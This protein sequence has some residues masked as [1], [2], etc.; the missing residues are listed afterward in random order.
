MKS[1]K[2]LLYMY[3]LAGFI[4]RMTLIPGQRYSVVATEALAEF[5]RKQVQD[6]VLLNKIK[7]ERKTENY[8]EIQVKNLT[9]SPRQTIERCDEKVARKKQEALDWLPVSKPR[10]EPPASILPTGIYHKHVGL[11]PNYLGHVPGEI[12]R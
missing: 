2:E 7:G 1:L 11:M 10:P 12:S 9:L 4:P 3:S 5:E 6:K 8:P